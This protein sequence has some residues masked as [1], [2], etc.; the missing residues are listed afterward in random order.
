MLCVKKNQ[1]Q[2]HHQCSAANTAVSEGFCSTHFLD[3]R[4]LIY[5]NGVK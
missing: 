4:Q 5:E 1:T 2:S 3:I